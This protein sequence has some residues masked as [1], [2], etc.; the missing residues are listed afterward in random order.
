MERFSPY[1]QVLLD[2]PEGDG[3]L[4]FCELH[5]RQQLHLG[6]VVLVLEP[7]TVDEAAVAVV[8]PL[9]RVELLRH[10][11]LQEIS[12]VLIVNSKMGTE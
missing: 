10:E 4:V 12:L 7:K 11:D 9:V 1:L 6:H 5:E 2:V 3:R 8:E